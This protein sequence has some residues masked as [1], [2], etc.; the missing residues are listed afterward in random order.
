MTLWTPSQLVAGGATY[1]WKYADVAFNGSNYV[2]SWPSNAANSTA[3]I[4]PSIRGGN[5]PASNLTVSGGAVVGAGYDSY[6]AL[7]CSTLSANPTRRTFWALTQQNFASA[8]AIFGSYGTGGLE[9]RQNGANNPL[10]FYQ[11]GTGALATGSTNLAANALSLVLGVYDSVGG[12]W[13]FRVNGAA[14][15]NGTFSPTLTGSNSLTALSGNIAFSDYLSGSIF[16]LGYSDQ[17]LSLADQQ[18]IEGYVAWAYGVAA[19]VLPIT[20]PYYYAAPT[21]VGASVGTAA[22]AAVILG[23]GV[24]AGVGVGTAAGAATVAGVGSATTQGVGSAAG[25]AV[26]SGV[27]FSKTNSLN[28]SYLAKTIVGSSGSVSIG[29]VIVGRGT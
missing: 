3:V 27:G 14:D 28:Y 18:R 11:I 9:F 13:S 24:A 8:W 6:P 2:T 19:T 15:A 22:G 4:T 16:E 26:I 23:V 29:N 7:T 5:G 10:C 17:V 12:V 21:V 25:L 20:H 1:E